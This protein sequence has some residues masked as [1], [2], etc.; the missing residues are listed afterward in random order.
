MKKN[1][2]VTLL[3]IM[4]VIGIIGM[5]IISIPSINAWLGHQGVSLAADQLRGEIQLARVMAI[6]RKQNCAI[7]VNASGL[8]QYIN[9][10]SQRCVRLS[11]Y[12]GGVHFL[13]EGP[14]GRP[15]ASKIVFNRRGMSTSVVPR[16]LFLAD[17]EMTRIY[18]IQVRLPGGIS[19][20]RWAK[21]HWY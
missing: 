18:R 17:A 10:L 15:A 3:E 8:D 13:S 19:V 6:N 5:T 9:T 1:K 4:I 11:E 2:G 7:A 16:D 12:R 20:Y 14:A 21:D